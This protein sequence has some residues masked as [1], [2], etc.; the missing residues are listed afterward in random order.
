M[1]NL[2]DSKRH[3]GRVIF[4]DKNKGFG[5]IEHP[6]FGEVFLHQSKMEEGFKV[7]HKNDLLSFEVVPSSRKKGVYEAMDVKF[8]LNENLDVIKDSLAN[9]V[10]LQGKVLNM[11]AGGLLMD[12]LGIEVFL[13]KSE[14]DVYEF[15]SY[16]IFLGKVLDIRVI[17]IDER[18]IIAS[19]K[20]ILEE[21]ESTSRR[22]NRES[23]EMN[24][25][26]S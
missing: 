13:P 1:D 23:N 15:N 3:S 5:R 2:N 8:I 16:S 17:G 12:V 10:T 24:K 22:M 7:A 4:Y 6:E 11:N 18:S 20:V 14:V 26:A 21:E 25:I 9:K 19:R